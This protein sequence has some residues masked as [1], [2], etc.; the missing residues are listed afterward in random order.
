MARLPGLP[1][2]ATGTGR[3][4]GAALAA[5]AGLTAGANGPAGASVAT[6]AAVTSCSSGTAVAAVTSPAAIASPATPAAGATR[7]ACS[8]GANGAA[9]RGCFARHGFTC[10][11]GS[12]TSLFSAVRTKLPPNRATMGRWST[13]RCCRPT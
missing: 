6:P 12:Q 2:L 4:A 1:G 10:L 5:R 13:S 9:A 7:S 8:S 3:A 11:S